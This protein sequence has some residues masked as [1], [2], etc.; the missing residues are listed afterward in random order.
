MQASRAG[1]KNSPTKIVKVWIGDTCSW[2]D[3][4]S[5]AHLCLNLCI[6]TGIDTKDLV[7]QV[8]NEALVKA[9][10]WLEFN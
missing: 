2:T 5:A 3:G 9:Y 7:Q 8:I 1:D 6:D 4:Y 10:V